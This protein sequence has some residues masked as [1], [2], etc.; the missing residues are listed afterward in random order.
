MDNGHQIQVIKPGIEYLLD[1]SD[2]PAKGVLHV[3]FCHKDNGVFKHGITSE[4]ILKMLIDR[5]KH[6]FDKDPSTDN[7]RALLFLTQ[8]L[9]S[10]NNRN[11]L[12]MKRRDD[13]KATNISVPPAGQ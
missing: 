8:A 7:S 9:Q 4:V 11:Y 1:T 3:V 6:L 13:Y 10:I 2:K 5:Q 12:K